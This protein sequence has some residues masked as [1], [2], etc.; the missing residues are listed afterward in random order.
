MRGRVSHSLV[1]DARAFLTPQA[2]YTPA[3]GAHHRAARD[4]DER[5][6]LIEIPMTTA[7]RQ[8]WLGTNLTLVPE[9]VGDVLT[10]AALRVDGPCVLELHAIDFIDDID[11]VAPEL[12]RAQPDLRVPRATKRARLARTIEHMQERTIVP[13][14]ALIDD[15]TA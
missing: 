6:A 10:S 11:G 5:R 7:L 1:G 12:I 14:R 15:V 4:D 8:P 3:R 2:P 9:R 13:L